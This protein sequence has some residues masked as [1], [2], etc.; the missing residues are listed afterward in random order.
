MTSILMSLSLPCPCHP[1]F[2][3]ITFINPYDTLS[4]LQGVVRRDYRQTFSYSLPDLVSSFGTVP[5]PL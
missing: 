3:I 1:V 5:L 2:S 4:S